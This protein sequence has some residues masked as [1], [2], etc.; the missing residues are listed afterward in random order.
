MQIFFGSRNNTVVH[1]R[2]RSFC[3]SEG[4]MNALL[5]ELTENAFSCI[6]SSFQDVV[7]NKIKKK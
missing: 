5:E 4:A 7:K 6:L 2:A 1:F 3:V